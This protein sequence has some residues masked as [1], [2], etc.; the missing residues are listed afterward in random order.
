MKTKNKYIGG[1]IAGSKFRFDVPSK[2]TCV[3][4][5]FKKKITIDEAAELYQVN[6]ITIKVWVKKFFYSYIQYKKLPA[7]TMTVADNVIL[8]HSAIDMAKQMLKKQNKERKRFE[9]DFA[10]NNFEK[11]PKLNNQDYADLNGV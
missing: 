7:G 1:K 5:I 6:P 11:S 10:T 4:M 9:K 2:C 8:G 3:E